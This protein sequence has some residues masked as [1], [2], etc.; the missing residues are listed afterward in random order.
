MYR[1][2]DLSYEVSVKESTLPLRSLPIASFTNDLII[3][4]KEKEYIYASG[5]DIY[6]K[7]Y[8]LNKN[9]KENND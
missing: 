2:V 6:E 7:I 3:L 1:N 9:T 4:K 5:E 8:N